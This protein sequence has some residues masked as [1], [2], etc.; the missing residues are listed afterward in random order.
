MSLLPVGA[1]ARLRF[2][3]GLGLGPKVE[4]PIVVAMACEGEGE[5]EGGG[6]GLAVGGLD[7]DVEVLVVGLGG[8]EALVVGGWL[9]DWRGGMFGAR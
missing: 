7:M 4:K 9:G 5:R 8:W 2:L 1:S 6:F 3:G